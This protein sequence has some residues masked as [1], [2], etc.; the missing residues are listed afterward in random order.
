MITY[1]AAS[2]EK[3][4]IRGSERFAGPWKASTF[5][6]NPRNEKVWLAELPEA[7]F[8][9]YNPFAEPN[10]VDAESNP[11]WHAGKTKPP[12]YLLARGLVFQ[13]GRRLQQKAGCDDLA[14]APGAYW[15]EPGGRRLHIRPFGDKDP[16]TSAFEI[17]TREFALAPEKTGLGFIRVDG[18]IIEYVASC[19][20]IPQR[21][22]I[23]T[24][25]GHHWIIQNNTVR[26][27]N[28]LGLDF[29]RR[30]TFAPYTVPEDTPELAGVGHI[31]RR[32]SFM[33]C[34]ICSMQGL[35]LFGGLI[36][37]N[38]SSGCGWHRVLRL[39]E[40]GGIKLHYLK[41]VLVRRNV[42]HGTIDSPGLWVDHSNANSRVTQN[43]VLG[44]DAPNHGGI[45]LEATYL[46]VLIDNNIV[47]GC[48]GHAF[49]QH[50][51]S[52]LIVAHNLFGECAK[53]PVFMR[54]N[55][56]RVLDIETNRLAKCVRNRVFGN[57]FYG[58][59]DR[60]P[61]MPKEE[62]ASDYNVFVDRPGE[63]PFDLSAWRK[64]TSREAH[65]MIFVSQM[66][67]SPTDWTL[68]RT[69]RIPHLQVVRIPAIA[70]DFFGAARPGE[71]TDAGP[72]VEQSRTHQV[73]LRG[74]ATP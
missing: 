27:V 4:V 25:Q 69:P 50:D 36:E 49:Y 31:I 72:L 30:P 12:Q 66:D 64:R 6:N 11:Y 17:T 45:F 37:D 51:C 62:N 41:H 18:F 53:R 65:S 52:D 71:T 8:D 23:S 47:W 20:P 10:V 74:N 70:F 57:V 14:D 33:D 56:K 48:N 2:G 16:K 73:R 39:W 1:E 32:N 13:D 61:E 42:V 54:F 9:G 7:L 38:F 28:S 29:G 19:F 5:A 24:R 58:F 21:G 46:P 67:L 68:R 55:A 43:I 15:V 63:N 35:G 60:G 59:G 22:A 34:G 26:Q 3:V 40:T 44:A